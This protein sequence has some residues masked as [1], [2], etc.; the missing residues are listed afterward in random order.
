M[1]MLF[2]RPALVGASAA[3]GFAYNVIR[4]FSSP[5]KIQILSIEIYFLTSWVPCILHHITSP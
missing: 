4:R 1:R 2:P 5:S 3:I